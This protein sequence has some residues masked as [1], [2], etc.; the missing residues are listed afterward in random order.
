VE[1][2]PRDVGVFLLSCFVP[3]PSIKSY[4]FSPGGLIR[5]SEDKEEQ[6]GGMRD[7]PVFSFSCPVTWPSINFFSTTCLCIS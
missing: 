2:E 7:V 6:E 3:M 1:G 4:F 5:E